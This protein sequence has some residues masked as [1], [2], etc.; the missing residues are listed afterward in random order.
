MDQENRRS[1]RLK[2]NIPIKVKAENGELLDMELVDISSTGMQ[3]LGDSL[4]ILKKRSDHPSQRV[5]FEV[6][7]VARLAWV[8]PQPDRTFAI[9][10]EFD[11]E[12][13]DRELIG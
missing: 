6:R 11:V 2:V 4:A 1:P 8:E 12:G 7:I 10:L 9:G 13:D 5:E 3:V